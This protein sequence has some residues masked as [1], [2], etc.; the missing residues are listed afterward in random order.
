MD[1]ASFYA[2]LHPVAWPVN[3]NLNPPTFTVLI[4]PLG[5]VPYAWAWAI[6]RA[7]SVACALAAALG[8]WRAGQL[9]PIWLGV[10]STPALVG[11]HQGQV[12]FVLLFLVTR[13]WLAATPIRAGLWLAPAIAIKPPLA[14]FALAL[15]WPTWLAAGLGS[16]SLSLAVLPITG[17]AP[18]LE[19]LAR[20]QSVNWIGWPTNLSLWGLLARLHADGLKPVTMADLSAWVPLVAVSSLAGLV[21]VSRLRDRASRWVAAYSLHLLV[22]PL[23]WTYYLPVMLAPLAAAW[24]TNPATVA[25]VVILM[26]PEWFVAGVPLSVTSVSSVYAIGFALAISGMLAP[27]RPPRSAVTMTVTTLGP[28]RSTRVDAGAGRDRVFP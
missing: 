9:H 15:P 6:W 28:H 14:L 24:R 11:W 27:S 20:S 3:L 1:F 19:W 26:L 2:A 12:T 7:V 25:G 17:L 8:V 16:A 13:A 22:T 18:W 4:W 10:L 21:A 23:G 5:L